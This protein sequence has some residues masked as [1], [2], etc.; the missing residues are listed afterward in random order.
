MRPKGRVLITNV[1]L[2]AGNQRQQQQRPQDDGSS[3]DSDDSAGLLESGEQF[4]TGE[5]DEGSVG[6]NSRVSMSRRSTSEGGPFWLVTRTDEGSQFLSSERASTLQSGL[7]LFHN[8]NLLT[9]S[10]NAATDDLIASNGYRSSTI[11]SSTTY[12]TKVA[13]RQGSTKAPSL[14]SWDQQWEPS[15]AGPERLSNESSEVEMW[16][17]GSDPKMV[18]LDDDEEDPFS[19]IHMVLPPPAL[20]MWDA[21][22]HHA[23][24]LNAATMC[25]DPFSDRNSSSHH[26]LSPT[27]SISS[28]PAWTQSQAAHQSAIDLSRSYL[29]GKRSQSAN[30]LRSLYSS[31]EA[32]SWEVDQPLDT[33]SMMGDHHMSMQMMDRGRSRSVESFKPWRLARRSRL[34][35]HSGGSV[36]DRSA[37]GSVLGDQQSVLGLDHVHQNHHMSSSR[38]QHR[39]RQRPQSTSSIMSTSSVTSSPSGTFMRRSSKQRYSLQDGVGAVVVLENSDAQSLQSFASVYTTDPPAFEEVVGEA[40]G[41]GL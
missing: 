38:R 25:D 40:A 3:P 37:N 28:A 29:G 15:D 21:P 20:N 18:D 2:C 31:F 26:A 19:D 7:R 14:A 12:G 9:N 10:N 4:G 32:P 11:G 24:S 39:N 6:Y 35:S 36:M 34:S 41:G 30:N 17:I 33:S 13:A 27:V 1:P 22:S 23:M 8:S 16:Q 5:A